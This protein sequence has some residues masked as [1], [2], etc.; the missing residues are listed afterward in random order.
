MNSSG[1]PSNTLSRGVLFAAL[2]YTLWGLFPL[3]FKQIAQ[4]PSLEVVAHRTLWCMVF[5][6]GVLAVL[7][8]WAW[9]GQVLRQPK[10]L[11]A[12]LLS[13]LL[14]SV[15]WLTYVWAVQ[16]DHVLDASLGYFINPLVNVA[17]GFAVLHERPRPGP[18][19]A[20]ASAAA[21]RAARQSPGPHGPV[22]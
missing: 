8:R 1:S 2:S 20:I 21:A 3:Y 18:R 12:F 19:P 7:K 9:L 4:V 10:V 6:L 16:N 5:L 13:A 11:A 14:L 22:G 17:L 15:N